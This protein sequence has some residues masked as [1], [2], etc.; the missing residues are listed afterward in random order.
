MVIEQYERA[1]EFYQKAGAT[2]RIA[3]CTAN[4]GEVNVNMGN[5]SIGLLKLKKAIEINKQGEHDLKIEAYFKFEI[6]RITLYNPEV[7]NRDQPILEALNTLEEIDYIDGIAY[8][9]ILLAQLYYYDKYYT[10]A[11]M[12]GEKE[13]KPALQHGHKLKIKDAYKILFQISGKQKDYKSAL[14]YHIGLK[15]TNDSLQQEKTWHSCQKLKPSM[16][17]KRKTIPF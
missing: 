10:K 4:I 12:H 1:I 11:K 9:N 13:L 15:H 3:S 17:L 6:G 7:K 5:D 14:N 16:K 2:S 8:G